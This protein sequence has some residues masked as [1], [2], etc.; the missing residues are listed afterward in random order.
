MFFVDLKVHNVQK[1]SYHFDRV[2]QL[3]RFSDLFRHN[4]LKENKIVHLLEA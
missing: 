4:L 3:K 2:V 1:Y